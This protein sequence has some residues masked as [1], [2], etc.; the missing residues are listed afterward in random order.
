MENKQVKIFQ[1]SLKT[2]TKFEA[3][4]LQLVWLVFTML[5]ILFA[6]MTEASST[7]TEGNDGTDM[8]GAF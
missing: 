1:R 5:V 3:G 2:A 6:G 8:V 4:I 7:I